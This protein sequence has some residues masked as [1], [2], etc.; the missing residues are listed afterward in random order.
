MNEDLIIPNRLKDEPEGD[1]HFSAPSWLWVSGQRSAFSDLVIFCLLSVHFVYCQCILLVMLLGLLS[2]SLT[3]LFKSLTSKLF[4]WFKALWVSF[5]SRNCILCF[6]HLSVF[7]AAM[8]S[9]H[10][11]RKP[12]SQFLIYAEVCL[13]ILTILKK[14]FFCSMPGLSAGINQAKIRLMIFRILSWRKQD[15]V[16]ESNI[17]WSL[18]PAW[19]HC[20]LLQNQYG[21]SKMQSVLLNI[22][23]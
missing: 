21:H 12:R 17:L 14:N 2:P 9:F 23:L 13:V 8:Y 1:R 10:S 20:A 7:D 4:G 16:I 11:K 5:L 3:Q 19:K 15:K 18:D 6:L 22:S